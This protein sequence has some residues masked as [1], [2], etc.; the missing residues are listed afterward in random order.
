MLILSVGSRRQGKISP[1]ELTA[2]GSDDDGHRRTQSIPA[3]SQ[4]PH[5]PTASRAYAVRGGTPP[6]L[7]P[8]KAASRNPDHD[9]GSRVLVRVTN[10]ET[11]SGKQGC[12]MLTIGCVSDG[13]SPSSDGRP[14]DADAHL[15]DADHASTRDADCYH[16]TCAVVPRDGCGLRRSSHEPVLSPRQE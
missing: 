13:E 9:R 2:S 1:G 16:C 6:P 15:G 7:P 14:I 10:G 12:R 4:P 8:L 11:K 5:G 3:H